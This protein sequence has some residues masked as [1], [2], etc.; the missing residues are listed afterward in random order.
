[1]I[2]EGMDAEMSEL[3]ERFRQFVREEDGPTAV[4][5]AALVGIIAAGAI[6]AMSNFGDQVEVIYTE[7]KGALDGAAPPA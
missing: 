1:M 4:E 6:V 3:N 5:Y 2:C 7:L